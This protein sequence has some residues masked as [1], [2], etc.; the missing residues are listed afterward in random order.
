[1][2]GQAG[3]STAAVPS[4]ALGACAASACCPELDAVLLPQVHAACLVLLVQLSKKTQVQLLSFRTGLVS[5]R[6]RLPVT[7]IPE[8]L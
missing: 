7:H 6:C 8:K 5:V 1:M 3:Q 4:K 2:C